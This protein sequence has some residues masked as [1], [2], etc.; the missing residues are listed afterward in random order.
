M[1]TE[2]KN[3]VLDITYEQKLSHLGSCLTAC[4]IIEEIYEIKKPEEPFI[5]SA[6]HAGLALYAVLETKGKA[7]ARTLLAQQGIHP[8]R[9]QAQNE[10]IVVSTGSLG[11][12]LP[13]ALGMALSD[14]KKNVY[15]LTSDG[16]WSEGSMW[17]ALRVAKEQRA[18]NLRI[19][20]NANGYAAYKKV[21]IDELEKRL[22]SFDFPV[23][24]RRTS[25]NLGTF[26]QGLASHYK[27]LTKEDYEKLRNE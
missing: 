26:A 20:V 9:L 16:E 17:E 14:R 12:G 8:D 7:Q 1:N 6:G 18:N 2:A 27:T 15:C 21:D 3:L 4:D 13:I 22:R 23:N 19:Y 10:E 5:L 25:S 24:I 11:Q